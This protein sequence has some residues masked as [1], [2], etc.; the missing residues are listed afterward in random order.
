MLTAKLKLL[1]CV[2]L[3]SGILTW[4]DHDK[5]LLSAD[6]VVMR[7][8]ASPFLTVGCNNQAI[9]TIGDREVLAESSFLNAVGLS[10]DGKSAQVLVN[11]QTFYVTEQNIK[12]GNQRVLELPA[13][14]KKL[15]LVYTVFL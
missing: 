10:G 11:N 2:Y 3:F 4:S 7:S 9:S 12:W 5:A 8:Y 14:W 6:V 15:E 13:D 1:R